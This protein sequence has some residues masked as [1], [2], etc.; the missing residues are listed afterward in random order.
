[1]R[2]V[3]DNYYVECVNEACGWSGLLSETK[4][5]TFNE[6]A[7]PECGSLVEPVQF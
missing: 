4:N 5:D 6:G 7:C 1:M 2:E 3:E